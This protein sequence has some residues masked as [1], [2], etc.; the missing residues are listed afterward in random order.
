M[1]SGKKI[2]RPVCPNC[3]SRNVAWIQWGRPVWSENFSEKLT[4][5][6]ITLGGC[7]V[8]KNSER[9]ECNECGNRF[10]Y[11]DF[12][13][14]IL[15]A[16]KKPVPDVLAA[17]KESMCNEKSIHK[18][19]LCGCFYCLEIF[20]PSEIYEWI[21]DVAGKTA[22]CPYCNIDSVIPDASG[23]PVTPEFLKEMH[24][25]WFDNGLDTND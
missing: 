25:Y 7:M 15:K 17:H 13:I 24:K 5:N 22:L 2:V 6:E 14:F 9:W 16:K 20:E 4:R 21:E 19:A 3:G 8:S 1:S 11:T 18:S 10:G 23:F 12:G